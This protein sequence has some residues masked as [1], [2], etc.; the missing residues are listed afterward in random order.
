MVEAV[1]PHRRD[2]SGEAWRLSAIHQRRGEAAEAEALYRRSATIKER[3]FGPEHPELAVTL[4]NLATVLRAQ[5]QVADAEILYRRCLEIWGRTLGR[6]DPRTATCRRNYAV[7]L[8]QAG[9]GGGGTGAGS[10]KR[11]RSFIG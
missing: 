4:N 10:V 3:V 8:R 6:D 5:A 9:R 11:T 2:R 1:R 7:L